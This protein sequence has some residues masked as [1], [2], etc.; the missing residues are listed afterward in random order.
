MN[1]PALVRV[2]A[3]IIEDNGRYL[4]CRRP[5]H[6]RHGGLWEFP[7]GKIEPLESDIDAARRELREELDVE[8][9]S[10]GREYFAVQDVGSPFLIAFVEVQ[11]TGTPRCCEHLELRWS[12]PRDI[13][14]LELAPSDRQFV[15]NS[16]ARDSAS[17]R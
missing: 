5:L 17:S 1:P 11:I 9:I 7:G 13:R 12:T 2:L 8:V 10:V 14:T 16:F 3:A 6:K 15:D 4:V